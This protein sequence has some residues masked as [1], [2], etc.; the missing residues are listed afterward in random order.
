MNW[1]RLLSPLAPLPTGCT[2]SCQPLRKMGGS[3]AWHKPAVM[4]N[5]T[6][7]KLVHL[8]GLNHAW[9]LERITAQSAQGWQLPSC[10][11]DHV[12]SLRIRHQGSPP[13]PAHAHQMLHASIWKWAITSLCALTICVWAYSCGTA[14]WWSCWILKLIIADQVTFGQSDAWKTVL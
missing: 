3:S 10:P 14:L 13:S 6:N 5:P 12:S 11:H 1:F 4:A 8:D 7:S 2:G 9:M